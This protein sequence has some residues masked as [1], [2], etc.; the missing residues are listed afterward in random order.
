MIEI[1][2]MKHSLQLSSPVLGAA[3]AFG[4]STEYARLIKL[5]KL[6]A[7]VTN[8]VTYKPRRVAHGTRVI[9]LDS[10]VLVHT[11]LP[12]PGINEVYRQNLARWQ[13]LDTRVILHIPAL[14][15]EELV[16]CLEVVE[17]HDGIAGVEIGIPD[18]VTRGEVRQIVATARQHTQLPLLIQL[19]MLTAMQLA[20]T[21]EEAGADALVIGAAPRG[22]VK[23]PYSGEFVGGRVYGPWVKAL[24]L[25][26][27]G[28]AAAKVSIPIIG[29]GGVFTP[30]DARDYL[31]AGAKA[32][33]V[34]ALAWIR[35]SMVEIIARDLGGLELTR[36]GGSLGDEWWPG[37][38]ETAVMRA[39]IWPSAPAAP[40]QPKD[41]PK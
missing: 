32:V 37:I 21:T 24:G 41:L 20:K 33:Q 12:N 25:R 40:P 5:E 27:V 17:R 35:P 34:D 16:R 28:S 19:P 23:D 4:F 2:S 13:K 38:G 31:A 22:T 15:T 26:A 29:A 18:D 39:Q 7:I 8:P 36:P 11:G 9:A 1:G 14:S 30:I 6:G 3:G 10:G